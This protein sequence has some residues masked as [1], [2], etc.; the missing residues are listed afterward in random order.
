[1]KVYFLKLSEAF[2][3]GVLYLPFSGLRIHSNRTAQD[4]FFAGS[5]YF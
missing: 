4:S 2:F 5:A 3:L 1:M